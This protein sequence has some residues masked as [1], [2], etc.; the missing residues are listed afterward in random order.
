MQNGSI[1]LTLPYPPPL[2]NLYRT[3]VLKGNVIRVKTGRAKSFA[4]EVLKVC[5]VAGI[6]PYIG[7]VAVSLNVYRPRRIGDLDGVFKA[8]FDGLKG[9]AFL[10]DKQIVE[11]Q[12]RRF[13]DP[14]NP[15]VEIEIKSLGLY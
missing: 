2:N 6:K 10:D 7:E 11:I 1:K 3:L 15:R 4:K 14:K 8:I 9:S 5:Q 12:A 13:E